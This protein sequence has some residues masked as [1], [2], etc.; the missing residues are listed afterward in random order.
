MVGS[1]SNLTERELAVLE[2]EMRARGK[3]TGIA[4]L[5]WF[6]LRMF[7]GHRFYLNRHGAAFLVTCIVGIV[8]TFFVVGLFVILVLALMVFIDAFRIP[9]FV[10]TT[11]GAIEQ[12]V[13][14]EILAARATIPVAAPAP[15]A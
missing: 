2:S 4:Y 12:Q 5:L 6:F 7:G 10:T 14:T 11:N 8:L 1:K 3:S 9:G 15:I 13:I